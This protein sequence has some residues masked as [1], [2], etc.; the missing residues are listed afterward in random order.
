MLF[1][2]ALNKTKRKPCA[3]NRH[4]EFFQ[5]IWQ[6]AYMILMTM[7]DKESLYFINV[8]FQIGNIRDYKIDSIHV[9]FRE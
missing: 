5:K 7:C 8:V 9:V 4:V 2:L 6:T 1:Q 3:V